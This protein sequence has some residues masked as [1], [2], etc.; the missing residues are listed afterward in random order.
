MK[1]ES[2][3]VPKPIYINIHGL[4]TRR[5][6]SHTRPINSEAILGHIAV[7]NSSPK[8]GVAGRSCR[9]VSIECEPHKASADA[10]LLKHPSTCPRS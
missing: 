5:R 7:Q 3:G 9:A 6:G 1:F 10:D 8:R 2:T 4:S